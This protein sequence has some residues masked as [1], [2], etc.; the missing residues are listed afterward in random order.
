MSYDE[1]EKSSS[2]VSAPAAA[3]LACVSSTVASVS[4][5]TLAT[6]WAVKAASVV[7]SPATDTVTDEASCAV[8][9]NLSASVPS[10]DISTLPVT[11]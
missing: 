1:V 5:P 9:L 8:M 11:F 7:L 4:L 6:S 3:A 10:M 2:M